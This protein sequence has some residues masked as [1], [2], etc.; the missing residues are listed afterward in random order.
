MIVEN[1]RVQQTGS[2][3]R[4]PEVR[5]ATRTLSVSKSPVGPAAPPRRTTHRLRAL[6]LVVATGLVL[7][8][9][10]ISGY[11]LAYTDDAYI[12]SD[13]VQVTPQV[14]GPVEA[15]YVSDN[16]WVKR[17]SI[18]ATI[19]PTPFKLQLQQAIEQEEEARAQLPVDA[20]VIE[21]LRAQKEAADAAAGLAAINLRRATPL[22][23]T[24]AVS[25]QEYDTLHTVQ[26]QSVARQHYAEATLEKA[27]QKLRL[28]QVAI[29]TAHAAR[30]YAEWRLSQTD[31]TAPVDGQITNL[32]LARGDYVSPSQPALAIVD[33]NAWRV[34]ANYKE[35][36]IRHLP[37]GRQVWVWLDT[38]PWHF[39]RA[40]VQGIAH[41]INRDQEASTLVPYVSPTVDWIRL[42]RRI[43]VRV[44]LIKP[45]PPQNLFMG[46]D[47]WVF[48]IY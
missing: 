17:G 46:S 48:A 25:K 14:A 41:A 30:L 28:Q 12:T 35:Y 32:R 44:Q 47:A 21:S 1:K 11:V 8:L 7:G 31:V 15:V 43:P 18:L 38:N 3:F 34:I 42:D 2:N 19:D 33:A 10:W 26:E 45:P 4:K 23:I 13:V 5:S 36:Y 6:L 24:G 40:R 20:A 16:Q 39:Y 29:A 27:I 22:S 9:W 37:P